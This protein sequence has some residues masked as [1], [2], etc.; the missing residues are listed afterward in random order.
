MLRF[1]KVVSYF[2][3]SI[4]SNGD[5]LKFCQKIIRGVKNEAQIFPHEQKKT[6][7]NNTSSIIE[8]N[9][10]FYETKH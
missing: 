5:V 2:F 4:V 9:E 3:R 10:S 6:K 1:L 8:A 7:K